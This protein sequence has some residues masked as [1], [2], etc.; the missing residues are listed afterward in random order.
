MLSLLTWFAF[1]AFILAAGAALVVVAKPDS[2]A[3]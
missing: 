1:H 2:A 3:K